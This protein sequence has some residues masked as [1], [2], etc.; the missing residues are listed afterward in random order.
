VDES[1]AK[2]PPPAVPGL[3]G[4]TVLARGGYSTVYRAV[5]S[6]IGRDV[7]VK[8]ENRA[9]GSPHDQ[10]RF[11]REARA[12]GRM[13]SHPHVVDLFDA[14][15]TND[16][17]PYLIMELCAGS[18]AERMRQGPLTAVEA[19]EVGVKIADA[20]ADGHDI[21]VLH[22]D[23]KP[24]NILITEFGEPTLADFGLAVLVESRDVSMTLEVLTP[25]YAPREMFRQGC[26]PSPAADV[27]SLC[28]TL[29]AL[30]RGKPPRWHHERDPS[31][32]SLLDLFDAP[33]P[34]LPG[35][36]AELISVLRTGMVNDPAAR[37]SAARLRDRLA[38]LSLAEAGAPPTDETVAIE[39]PAPAPSPDGWRDAWSLPTQQRPVAA[40][41]PSPAAGA[42][43]APAGSS[44][45][46]LP[47]AGPGEPRPAPLQPIEPRF[48]TPS[49]RLPASP[50]GQP[51]HPPVGHPVH[52]PGAGD[53][54]PRAD[55]P[56]D[57]DAT[58]RVN[59]R[60]PPIAGVGAVVLLLGLL[61]TGTT[62]YGLQHR[63]PAGQTAGRTRVAS[64]QGGTGTRKAPAAT[65]ASVAVTAVAGCGIGL[66]AANCPPADECFDQLRV[67]DGVEQAPILSCTGPH[68]WEVFAVGRLSSNEYP[69]VKGDPA[70]KRLCSAAVLA[71]V[72]LGAVGWRVDVLPPAPEAYA[73]GDRTFRC[74]AGT[75]PNRQTRPAF[76]RQ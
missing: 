10:H 19:R 43:G 52:Q 17:H 41:G 66:P 73:D 23:V 34:D 15:V 24:A 49:G 4:L 7:A 37:P 74:L 45:A 9:L 69:A 1:A 22:R 56:P 32:I 26:Q 36:P 5:Q 62:W 18:Y 38:G 25:A 13:S 2:Q 50:A 55:H 57:P 14:G 20:L 31:L 76:P 39:P 47:Q 29:Y 53:A 8:I 61:V 27:Y 3:T 59:R 51:G 64:L 60:I 30:M 67:A 63:G 46:D 12:A 40:G 72:D 68:T 35:V 65:P 70:V 58:V 21:G 75:G 48:T 44:P 6:S 16:G 54:G 42:P 11:L 33:I 28:A 71:T